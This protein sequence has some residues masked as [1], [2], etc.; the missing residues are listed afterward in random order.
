LAAA[1]MERKAASVK[2]S[3]KAALAKRHRFP[4]I[5]LRHDIFPPLVVAHAIAPSN[6]FA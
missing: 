6:T 4:G 5:N 1:M 3:A 2:N